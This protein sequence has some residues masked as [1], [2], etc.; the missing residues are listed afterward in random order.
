MNDK[1]F[2]DTNVFV[3]TFDKKARK[4]QKTAQ[5][6]IAGALST[7]MG[8]ISFQVVQEFFNVATRKF[9]QPMKVPDCKLYLHKILYPLCEVLPSEALYTTAL[10]ITG[11]TQYSFYDSLILAAAAQAQCRVVYT[12]DLCH[13][14][15]VHGVTIVNPFR[16]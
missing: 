10:E 11:H 13:E 5:D 16:A 1:C 2:I 6:L 7:G 9:S 4:K 14:R 3:Y 8:V 15:S 12:E